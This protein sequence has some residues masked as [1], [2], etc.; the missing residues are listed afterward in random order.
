MPGRVNTSLIIDFLVRQT[1][2]TIA[3][4]ATSGGVRAPLAHLAD[5][6]FTDVTRELQAQG[7]RRKVIADMF[8]ITLRAYHARTQRLQE[9][10]T[11]R[12]TSLWQAVYQYVAEHPSVSL[13][14]LKQRFRRDNPAT[15][16]S[17]VRDLQGADLVR[18]KGR[19]RELSLTEP[20]HASSEAET[21]DALVWNLVYRHGPMNRHALE[22]QAIGVPQE[23]L[24]SAVLRLEENGRVQRSVTSGEEIVAAEECVLP[25]SEPE[26]HEAALIDHFQA[27]IS[28]LGDSA[29]VLVGKSSHNFPRGGV[30][31]HFDLFEDDPL[32]PKIFGLLQRIRAEGAELREALKQRG[33]AQRQGSGRQQRSARKVRVT[34]YAGQRVQVEDDA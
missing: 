20:S 5:Q 22:Q 21:F 29:E 7:M 27:A 1:M 8:G 4:L 28:N 14:Q 25:L 26:G 18:V 31:F 16:A 10:A 24:S 19:S 2:V 3:R 6:V 12:G 23:E 9:S 17:I 32:A 11:E 34:F 33:R 13:S 15:V 30:T